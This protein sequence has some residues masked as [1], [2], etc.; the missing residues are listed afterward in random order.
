MKVRDLILQRTKACQP[1]HKFVTTLQVESVSNSVFE[2]RFQTT[3]LSKRKR[4][5]VR[6]AFLLDHRRVGP[7]CLLRDSARSPQSP[8]LNH[9]PEFDCQTLTPSKAIEKEL[10]R[11]GPLARQ[12]RKESGKMWQGTF[13]KLKQEEG[14]LY[15]KDDIQQIMEDDKK[16]RMRKWFVLISSFIS[17]FFLTFA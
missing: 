5:A 9:L 4:H 10:K 17:H 11:V 15:S 8:K 1:R 12:A 2:F 16:S 7:C 6:A 3:D 14:E 13:S